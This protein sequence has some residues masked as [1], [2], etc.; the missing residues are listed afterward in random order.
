MPKVVPEYKD[1]ARRRIIE[2]AIAEVD[3]K[4]FSNLKMEDVA[5]RLGISRATLY[6]Y[7]KSRDDL[8][9]SALAYIRSRLSENLHDACSENTP[10]DMFSA[11]FDRVIYPEDE[12]GM[13]AII[14]LFAGAVRDDSLRD[15]VGKN[16]RAIHD[17]LT[18]VLEEEKAAGNLS[19]DLDTDLSARII[20]SVILGIRMGSAAG[21]ERD[22][23]HRIWEAAVRRVLE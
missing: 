8:I 22:E 10:E 6:L 11:I 15:A 7:V 21:L 17:L 16:Y 2:A 19:S 13:K 23:A 14:E 20:I 3:E 12:T 5:A 18:A 9:S 4:G 1:E